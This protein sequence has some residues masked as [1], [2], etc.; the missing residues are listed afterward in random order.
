MNK[1]TFSRAYRHIAG[2]FIIVIPLL[3]I[4]SC[5]SELV[6]P[7]T[8]YPPY[9]LELTK[10]AEGQVKISWEYTAA[11]ADTVIYYI[12]KKFGNY[13]WYSYDI[14]YDS[15]EY[16]DFIPTNETYV[17]SYQ[18]S[19]YNLS[20]GVESIPSDIVAYF[21]EYSHPTDLKLAQIGQD[22]LEI[23]WVDNSIGEEGFHLDRKVGDENWVEKYRTFGENTTLYIDHT[24]LYEPVQYRVYAFSGI[25]NTPI[26]EDTILPTLMPPYDLTLDKLDIQQVRLSWMDSNVDEEG[27][28]IDKKIGQTDW[29]LDYAYVD[30]STHTF[31]DNIDLPCGDFYYRVRA[32]KGMFSSPFSTEE[33]INIFIDLIG[34]TTTSGNSSDIYIS[35]ETNWYTVISDNYTGIALIDCVDPSNPENQNYNEEGLPDRTNS[36]FVRDNKAY[37]TT[38]S[39]LEEHGR[40]YVI[41]LT[42]ILPYHGIPFPDVLAIDAIVPISGNPDDSYVPYDIYLSG[43]YA[44]IADGENGLEILNIASA[45]PFNVGNLQMDGIAKKVYVDGSY[46]YVST[47]LDGVVVVDVSNPSSPILE[48]HYA[49]NGGNSLDAVERDGFVFIADGENGL[50]IVNMQSGD[51]S[52]VATGGFANGIYVQGHDRLQ[53]DHVY[54]L[55]LEQGLFIIDITDISDPYILGQYVM[56]TEPVAISKFFHSSYVFVADNEGLKIIQVAP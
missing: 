51:A 6:S 4:L 55:D 10:I 39:G 22:E 16:V 1:K 35:E 13:N 44:Y 30:S 54:L 38:V 17:Y 50:K 5:N 52:Y 20:T 23:T 41:D 37:V 2:L 34:S 15:N 11:S 31:I 48:A 25:T 47:G 12:S 14:I 7:D 18:I 27:Y 3:L 56:D 42:E 28:Y 33:H 8:N 29:I 32:V 46:A 49:S 24:T 21:S 45:T 19:A 9:N 36:V 43:D 40:L 53:E 26:L